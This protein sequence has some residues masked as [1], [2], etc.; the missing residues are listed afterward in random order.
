[1]ASS[2][3][4]L[5][6]AED[7][8]D[9][10]PGLTVRGLHPRRNSG[11]SGTRARMNAPTRDE[12]DAEEERDAPAPRE[13]RLLGQARDARRR[14]PSRGEVPP[15]RPSA[16]SSRRS[17]RLPAGRVLDRHQ[18][19]AAPLA[20]EPEALHEAQHHEQRSAP[21]GPTDVVGRQEADRERR[22]AH[23]HQRQ[24]EHRLAPDP[25]AEVAEDD[26]AHRP[27]DEADRERREREQRADQRLELREEEPRLKTSAAAV[28]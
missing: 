15:A 1:M 26:A 16:A 4:A 19:G 28:P 18:D 23:E 8:D 24:A 13:E 22:H 9:R 6:L 12:H 2:D 20:A 7:L 14:R 27:R 25:I 17:R 10:Q 21:R 11:L 3:A 5:V